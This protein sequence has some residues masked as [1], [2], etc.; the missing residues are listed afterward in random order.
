MI[1]I[2]RLT[3][4][5]VPATTT[6]SK[7]TN[8]SQILTKMRDVNNLVSKILNS[9]EVPEGIDDKLFIGDLIYTVSEFLRL[10]YN[11]INY[12]SEI[13]SDYQGNDVFATYAK[14]LDTRYTAIQG[15]VDTFLNTMQQ[16]KS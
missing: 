1:R 2:K 15:K 11:L 9:G 10:S 5:T 4:K 7:E 8:L 14:E 16:S 13:S 3:Q 6:D 12:L